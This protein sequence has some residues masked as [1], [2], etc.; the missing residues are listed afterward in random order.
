MP[1]K[2]VG[3]DAGARYQYVNSGTVLSS[4]IVNAP[5][6]ESYRMELLIFKDEQLEIRGSG[7]IDLTDVGAAYDYRNYPSY[8]DDDDAMADSIGDSEAMTSL[9]GACVVIIIVGV[10]IG[11][12]VYAVVK[13][14]DGKKKQK[15][16]F[17]KDDPPPQRLRRPEP[18]L[19]EFGEKNAE[20][21]LLEREAKRHRNLEERRSEKFAPPLKDDNKD[22][23]E[24][25]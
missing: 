24:E 10:I 8:D 9:G 21:L 18:K 17:F 23:K 14:S 5:N 15:Q 22:M 3:A 11:I 12:I 7:T 6:N 20:E 1:N 4:T 19:E 16:D 13:S 2:S 25:K